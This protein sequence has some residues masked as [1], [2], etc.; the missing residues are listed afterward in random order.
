M[1]FVAKATPINII[2][3]TLLCTLDIIDSRCHIKNAVGLV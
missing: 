2:K 3:S 1:H